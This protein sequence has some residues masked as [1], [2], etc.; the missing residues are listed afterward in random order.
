MFNRKGK[1]AEIAA[2]CKV[3]N[4]FIIVISSAKYTLLSFRAKRQ[5]AVSE[6]SQTIKVL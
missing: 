1:T 6:E 2:C 3:S 4:E 5:L